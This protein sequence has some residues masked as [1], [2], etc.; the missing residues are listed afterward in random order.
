MSSFKRRQKPQENLE[1][2][3]ITYADAVT[4]LLCFFVIL[5]SISE[6]KTAKFE[7]VRQ[8][9]MAEFSTEPTETPF[10]G[11]FDSLSNFIEQEDLDQDALVEKTDSGIMFEFASGLLFDAGSARLKPAAITV[12]EELSFTLVDFEFKDYYVTVEGHTDDI[13][14]ESE[15]FPSN[16]ELSA[17]RATTVVRFLI[18]QGID[19]NRIRAVG[20]ADTR[21]K[22]PNLDVTGE[23]IEENRA[24]NRRIIINLDRDKF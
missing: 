9:L 5:L 23:P 21:P 7:E 22:L 3:L 16:W 6:P 8:G 1:D 13:P 19:V 15:Q 11:M 12:L 20:Y 4:L 2:W 17:A 18:E 10:M 14:I 24:L